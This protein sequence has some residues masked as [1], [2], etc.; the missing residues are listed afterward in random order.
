MNL[1]GGESFAF[2]L[3]C[4]LDES[5]ARL[6]QA[7]CDAAAIQRG[8]ARPMNYRSPGSPTVKSNT[9]ERMPVLKGVRP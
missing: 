4:L 2:G 6:A 7:D 1:S 8:P 5:A 3:G 9:G